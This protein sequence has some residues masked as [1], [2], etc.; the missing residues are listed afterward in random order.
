MKVQELLSDRTKW[1]Q[2]SF[3]R[4]ELDESAPL[5]SPDAVCWCLV[6][7]LIKCYGGEQAT[8]LQER[9]SAH[10]KI[11][12]VLVWNDDATYEQVIAV[13]KELDL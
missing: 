11:N 6:G 13:V 2:N 5:N 3:A 8:K 7:A 9:I 12:S 1:T 4:D 10:L